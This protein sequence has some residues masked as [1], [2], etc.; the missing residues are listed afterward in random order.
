MTLSTA[1]ATKTTYNG[2]ANY[3]TWNVSLWIQNDEGMYNIAKG[4]SEHGYKSLSH[5][6]VELYGPQ[7]PDG[8][9]WQDCELDIFELSD[10]LEEL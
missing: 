4:Y 1:T 7:T 10:M 9:Y 2:W 3:E 8:V 5:V 6:L